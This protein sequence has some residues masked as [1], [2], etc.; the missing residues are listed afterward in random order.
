[1]E[2]TCPGGAPSSTRRL[3]FAAVITVNALAA[4][5]AAPIDIQAE[6]SSELDEAIPSGEI[7][8]VPPGIE[9]GV[10]QGDIGTSDLPNFELSEQNPVFLPGDE[11]AWDREGVHPGVVI[12]HDGLFHMFYNG[13]PERG[14]FEVGYAVSIDGITWNRLRDEPILTRGQIDAAMT[15][16]TVSSILVDDDGTWVM[17]VSMW[18]VDVYG[19]ILR[20][21]IY[22]ASAPEPLGPW[23]SDG[24]K[25]LSPGMTGDWDS[26]WIAHPEVVETADGYRMYFTGVNNR[27]ESAI[28]MA[29][30]SDGITWKKY[31]DPETTNRRYANSDA[32]FTM[33]ESETWDEAGVRYPQIVRQ[34]ERWA[35]MYIGYKYSGPARWTPRVGY[36]TSLDGIHWER[37]PNNPVFDPEINLPRYEIMGF[38]WLSMDTFEF[39]Y[40][41]NSA[42][43]VTTEIYLATADR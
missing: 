18:N 3:F 16:L 6:E 28:G 19:Q 33:G 1:M 11:T 36:A 8:V 24:E 26:D 10:P 42:D 29:T 41:N 23:I 7:F 2:I 32:I 38:E 35:M 20:T 12:F 4:S 31:N 15:G 30:S 14:Q 17:Y 34:G 39:L 21:G 5:C 25:L 9:T 43:L 40:F 13:H 22:R 27:G 37:S